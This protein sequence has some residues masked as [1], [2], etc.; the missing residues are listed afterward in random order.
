MTITLAQVYSVATTIIALS[1]SVLTVV[2]I[3]ALWR[4]RR[5]Y[6]KADHLLERIYSD[7]TPITHN[8]NV[9]SENLNYLTTAIRQDIQK[10]SATIGDANTRVEDAMQVTERR[11]REFNALL[12]VAQEEAEHLF[13]STASTMRGVRRGA[14][15]LRW[16]GGTDLASDELDAAGEADDLVLQE[17]G[18][19]DDSSTQPSTQALPAAPRVRPRAGSRRRI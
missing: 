2:A 10:V 19:G 4:F 7:I 9:I 3:P 13:L 8:V 18:D 11:V 6:R 17:E 15:A 1:L 14:E 16:R 12:A 5:T